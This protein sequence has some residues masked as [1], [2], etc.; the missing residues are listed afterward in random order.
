[1]YA[2]ILCAKDC[3]FM[4][5]HANTK[6]L[7]IRHPQCVVASQIFTISHFLIIIKSPLCFRHPEA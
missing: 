6:R 5:L 2:L 4:Y 7:A 3:Y 1:M